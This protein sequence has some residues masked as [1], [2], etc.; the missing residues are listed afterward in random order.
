MSSK[1]GE[2]DDDDTTVDAAVELR[3]AESDSETS[4]DSESDSETSSDEEVSG[5]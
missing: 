1:S 3:V 4:E 5:S 2:D